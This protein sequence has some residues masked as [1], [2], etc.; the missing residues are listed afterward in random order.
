ML[1][2][3]QLIFI[4]F[5]SKFTLNE[6]QLMCIDFYQLIELSSYR[7]GVVAVFFDLKS[8]DQA[9]TVQF[10]GRDRSG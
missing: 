4:D 9:E 7:E 8:A 6:C 5:C 10:N 2:H 3:D 1:F